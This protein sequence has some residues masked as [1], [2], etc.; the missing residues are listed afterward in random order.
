[1]SPLREIP[2]V[3]NDRALVVVSSAVS[4][5]ISAV[6]L[7]VSARLL[8]P[9]E[10]GVLATLLAAVSTATFL[11]RSILLAAA[12]ASAVAREAR[13]EQA[14]RGVCG[15]ALVAV[16]VWGALTL[17]VSYW[18]AHP[19]DRLLHTGGTTP[20]LL[21][22]LLVAVLI[23]SQVVAGLLLGLERTGTYALMMTA[24]PIVRTALT[25]PLIGLMGA[26]GAIGA[27]VISAATACFLGTARIGCPGWKTPAEP[28][29]MSLLTT[30][31]ASAILISIT[32][33]A[34]YM[35]VLSIRAYAHPL[36]AG[37]YATANTLA[38]VLFVVG[39]PVCLAAYPRF[40][41]AVRAG[42]ARASH[43]LRDASTIASLGIIAFVASFVLAEPV[44][45]LGLGAEFAGAASL[46]PA[47]TAKTALNLGL[48]L[49]GSYGL[50]LHR[51]RLVLVASTPAAIPAIVL[52]IL[53]PSV[54]EVALL[55]CAA[56][57]VGIAMCL[58][59]TSMHHSTEKRVG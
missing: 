58:V 41:R 55:S 36:E 10:F 51:S 30:A 53:Q 29:L 13:Q 49:I 54:G 31:V 18:L 27:F 5:V 11:T 20:I 22:T 56:T 50:A 24:D 23:Y 15:R 16:T 42:E 6:C 17:A 43:L 12:R 19:I 46:T 45:V 34:Q 47:L 32:A 44:V 59:A 7:V 35:D 8:G 33:V 38:G 3:I 2:I 28:A 57:S 26:G 25:I 48:L 9:L 52:P 40:V 21:S 4:A 39:M 14:L 37:L 1:V